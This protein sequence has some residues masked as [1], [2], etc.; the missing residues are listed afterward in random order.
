MV[1]FVK[2]TANVE[3]RLLTSHSVT[4]RLMAVPSVSKS[5]GSVPDIETNWT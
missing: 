1:R 4:R 2:L 5:T 3:D